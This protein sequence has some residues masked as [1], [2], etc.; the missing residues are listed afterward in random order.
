LIS[1]VLVRFI[2]KSAEFQIFKSHKLIRLPNN[3]PKTLKYQMTF[4]IE[5]DF[6]IG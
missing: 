2:A 4:I 1:I 3:N 6:S 5:T